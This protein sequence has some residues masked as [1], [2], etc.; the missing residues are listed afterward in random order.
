M[1]TTVAKFGN[2][3]AC[4]IGLY[5]CYNPNPDRIKCFCSVT[6]TYISLSSVLLV[7]KKCIVCGNVDAREL[8]S[9]N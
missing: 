2:I 8:D 6:N 1:V 7:T 9:T 5:I 4:Y 3:G